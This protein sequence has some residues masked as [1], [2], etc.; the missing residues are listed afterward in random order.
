MLLGLSGV[1]GLF[2][3]EVITLHGVSILLYYIW[4]LTEITFP[5]LLHFFFLPDSSQ[6]KLVLF[7][8]YYI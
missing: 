8:T 6:E 4:K 1:G 3:A 7:R 5:T 2:N